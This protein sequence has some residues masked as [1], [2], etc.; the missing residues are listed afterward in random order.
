MNTFNAKDAEERGSEMKNEA[1]DGVHKPRLSSSARRSAGI[2]LKVLAALI[3]IFVL[4]RQFAGVKIDTVLA[5]LDRVGFAMIFVLVPP[6]LQ[7]FA[8]TLGLA[9]CIPGVHPVKSIAKVL[10]VRIGCDALLNSLP[11]GVVAAETLRPIWLRRACRIPIEESVAACLMGKINMAA[12]QGLFIAVIMVL[13]AFAGSG[14]GFVLS[15]NTI[16]PVVVV[17]ILVFAVVG[18][19]YSGPRVTQ[20]FSLLKRIAWSR[21]QHFLSRFESSVVQIDATILGFARKGRRTVF[22]SLA[23]FIVGWLLLGLESYV[24]L[25][26]LGQNISVG[27][28][29]LMEGTASLLRIAFFFIPS[30][31]GAVEAAY[32][33][34]IASFGVADPPSIALAFIAIKR[35]QEVLW[36]VLGYIALL[37]RVLSFPRK[38]AKLEQE[39]G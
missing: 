18:Y 1:E 21:W 10:P 38:P 27:Q 39:R 19:V 15:V 8:E 11:A 13:L 24:I 34:L 20:L 16:V 28:G 9:L 3:I 25:R 22:G 32:V 26:I 35:S 37:T 5:L 31:F 4:W 6:L 14:H 12:A 23:A 7:L 30:A 36:I 33:S 29:F 2:V 17:F